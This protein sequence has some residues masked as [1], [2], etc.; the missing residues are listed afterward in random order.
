MRLS[1]QYQSVMIEDIGLK[2]IINFASHT[3]IIFVYIKRNILNIM[4]SKINFIC[5]L[6]FVAVLASLSIRIYESVTVS[7]Q[8]ID[9]MDKLSYN[10]DDIFTVVTLKPN[11]N[12]FVADSIYNHITKSYIPIQHSEIVARS[13]S[14]TD[15]AFLSPIVIILLAIIILMLY[16]IVCFIKLIKNINHTEIFSW[17]NVSLL[18]RIGVSIIGVFI[19]NLLLSFT[20]LLQLQ[21]EFSFESYSIGWN[22]NADMLQI[23]IGLVCFL[24]AEVFAM[25]LK[26]KEEQDLTI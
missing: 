17:R 19:A 13:Q 18:R 21:K 23:I 24:F 26:I 8:A 9:V 7:L 1:K 16:T 25:G 5:V 12:T 15:S 20:N 22:D 4:K 10:E 6:I 11:S 2:R 14:Q 3:F